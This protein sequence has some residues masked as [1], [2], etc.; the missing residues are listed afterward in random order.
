MENQI[1]LNQ[2]ELNQTKIKYLHFNINSQYLFSSNLNKAREEGNI[3]DEYK[4][5]NRFLS[6]INNIKSINPNVISLCEI[7]NLDDAQIKVD[8]FVIALKE[9]GYTIFSCPYDNTKHSF[10]HIFGFKSTEFKLIEQRNINLNALIKGRDNFYEA[11]RKCSGMLLKERT[12]QKKI[13]FFITHFH[14]IES[15]KLDSVDILIDRLNNINEPIILS[16]DFNFFGGNNDKNKL[17]LI[18]S[19][20]LNDNTYPIKLEDKDLDGS[21][22]GWKFDNFKFPIDKLNKLDYI[23]TKNL[24]N[25]TELPTYSEGISCEDIKNNVGMSDHI[26]LIKEFIL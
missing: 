10:Y 21:F 25:I 11:E 23:F 26:P 4:L 7:R 6:I 19:L 8:N 12:T 13:W 3:L 20:N 16:G 18:N 14:V 1:K 9:F 15:H 5:D 2:I 24:G 22:F 17:K